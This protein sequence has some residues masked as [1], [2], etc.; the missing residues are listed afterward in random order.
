MKGADRAGARFALVLG[1]Q[2]LTNGEV[3][4]KNLES[5]EQV[6]VPLQATAIIQAVS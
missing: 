4:V 6:A 1:D 5:H 2:E 3:A